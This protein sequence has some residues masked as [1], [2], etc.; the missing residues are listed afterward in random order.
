MSAEDDNYFGGGV[1]DEDLIG[2]G[3]DSSSDSSSDSG[4]DTS[5]ISDKE[6]GGLEEGEGED[7]SV[8]SVAESSDSD[9]DSELEGGQVG[10]VGDYDDQ[11]DQQDQLDQEEQRVTK[12]GKKIKKIPAK[13][14][15]KKTFSDEDVNDDDDDEEGE[16]YLKKFDREVNENYILNNHPECVS[17]NYDEILAM[18]TVVR[19]ENNIIIDDL[20]RT[21]P[22][23]T[24]Y[25]RARILG[26][27]AKQ[28]ETG[29]TPFVKVP[30]NIIDS[31]LIAEMELKQVRIP[32]IIRRPLPN[33]GSEYWKIADLEN[34][35]F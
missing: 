33:G 35:A 7:V 12:S 25:E 6:G 26:Q 32:F 29:A 23:L 18:T 30:E 31:Y 11:P 20:H 5:S 16:M 9:S 13:K 8:N 22:F 10:G 27:R 21:N 1:D 14:I 4:S 19:D 24:K 17:Q 2:G 3:D 34:I 15:V 28:I